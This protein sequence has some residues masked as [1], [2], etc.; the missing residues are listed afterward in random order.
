M[1]CERQD[2]ISTGWDLA[3]TYSE[4]LAA[5]TDGDDEE[6]ALLDAFPV[7][8]GGRQAHVCTGC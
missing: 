5:R 3:T 4:H 2:A 6:E 8:G 1:K 7:H